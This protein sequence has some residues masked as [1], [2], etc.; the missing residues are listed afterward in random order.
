MP[1]VHSGG[2]YKKKYNEEDIEK[3]LAAMK[4]GISL[5]TAAKRYNIPRATLQ[6]RK[7]PKFVKTEFGPSPILTKSEEAKLVSWILDCQQK[8]FPRRKEDVQASVKQFLTENPRSNPF[9][10]NCPGEGWM[11]AFL[12]RNPVL[13]NRTAEGVSSAS[14]N[15]SENDIRGWFKQIDDYLKNKG[16][17]DI[18]LDPS[19]IFNSDE[20][21]FQLCA[22]N[23]KVLAARGSKN[24]YQ[25]EGNS[26]TS[27]TVLFTFNAI[28]NAVSPL[29]VYPYKRVPQDIMRTFPEDWALSYSDSGWMK[30]D[31]FYEFIGNIFHPFLIKNNIKLPII[32]FVD[33]HKTHLDL[34]LSELCTKLQ[35]ILIAL[36]PNSTRIL[37][38]CDVSAFRPIKSGWRKGVIDW[39]LDNP[40]EDITKEKF[41]SILKRV[42]D[43]VIRPE[44]LINGFRA[45]GLYPWDPNSIDYTKCL[46]YSKNKNNYKPLEYEKFC[47]IVGKDRIKRFEDASCI[48][49]DDNLECLYRIWLQY[50][51]S[52]DTYCNQTVTEI[53]EEEIELIDDN[54]E[55]DK[56][57]ETTVNSL[58][59]E[60]VDVIEKVNDY[61]DV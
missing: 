41:A 34:H 59:L 36:Y 54:K 29:V 35:I 42:V 27:I 32:L 11:K 13:R 12:K 37:Q 8:G 6:F 22:Q 30:T 60:E 49:N 50:E 19:R 26:K 15:V 47:K 52:A 58:I 21:G 4:S 43:K 31:I 16:L 39:R 44:I 25:V 14:A 5:R 23:K 17:Q 1:K 46:G 55:I 33:G 61:C 9:T 40:T 57:N 2:S 38:P 53:E 48:N 51:S 3:A 7:S 20:T 56:C 45:C 24:V 28:G 18:F 10:D